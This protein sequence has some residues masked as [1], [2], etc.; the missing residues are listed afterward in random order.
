MFTLVLISVMLFI[1]VTE[2]RELP[3]F[4]MQSTPNFSHVV[5]AP[6]IRSLMHLPLPVGAPGD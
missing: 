6:G 4:T 5:G 3:N 1:E 2:H